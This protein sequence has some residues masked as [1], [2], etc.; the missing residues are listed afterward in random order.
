M[1]RPPASPRRSSM[2]PFYAI[3]GVMALAGIGFFLYRSVGK[4]A[5]ATEPVPVVLTADQLNRVKGISVGRDDAPVVIWEFADFQCPGCGQFATFVA[6]L[7]KDRLVKAGTV[8]YV[9]YD[10]PLPMHPHA[11]LAA[12]A[13]R[14][15]NEQGR[16]WEYHDLVFGKQPQWSAVGDATD[17]FLQYGDQV[18]LDRGKFEECVRSDRYVR[19]ISES[20]Q[21][22]TSL[23]V[24]GTPTLFVNGKRLESTPSFQELQQVVEREVGGGAAGA[25]PAAATD[26]SAATDTARTAAPAGR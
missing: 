14:C 13:A 18:G 17:V 15:A 25:A 19:E 6:P 5:P 10:F 20:M 26:T 7:I 21:L 22:G 9:F 1:A 2:T 8:K 12:R 11:F 23:G 16:F 4:K 3:L 24:R